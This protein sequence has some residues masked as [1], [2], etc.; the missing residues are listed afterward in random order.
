MNKNKMRAM[1]I[2]SLVAGLA[3]ADPKVTQKVAT[4]LKLKPVDNALTIINDKMTEVPDAMKAKII[5]KI[6]KSIG[7][8]DEESF[9]KMRTRI[10]SILRQGDDEGAVAADGAAA[11]PTSIP[12]RESIERIIY[13][14]M[15]AIIR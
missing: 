1:I 8:T 14:E 2:E 5:V 11:V 13:E 4:A 7:I 9:K 3:E 12:T 6:L 15:E 10:Q